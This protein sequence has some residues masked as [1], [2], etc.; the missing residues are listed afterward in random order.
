VVLSKSFHVPT[1]FFLHSV[2]VSSVCVLTS[3]TVLLGFFVV[4]LP[5][6]SPSRSACLST[7]YKIWNALLYSAPLCAIMFFLLPSFSQGPIPQ[8]SWFWCSQ[9]HPSVGKKA[10][11]VVRKCVA[12][13][14]AA[15]WQS[16]GGTVCSLLR[17]WSF[18][19]FSLTK[20]VLLAFVPRIGELF[21]WYA[22]EWYNSRSSEFLQ[23]YGKYFDS[24]W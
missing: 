2:S 19:P 1:F 7:Q 13:L 24:A 23:T 10:K 11:Q 9:L 15:F 14:H 3:S 6:S 16:N 22:V 17:S 12:S 20:C 5:C 8:R 4:I 21:L 18:K